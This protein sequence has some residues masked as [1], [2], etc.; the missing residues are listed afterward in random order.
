[1]PTKAYY[2]SVNTMVKQQVMSPKDQDYGSLVEEKSAR[3]KTEPREA[4]DEESDEDGYESFV[5]EKPAG[6]NRRLG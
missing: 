3:A 6:Q 5:E 1:M 4:S 2:T